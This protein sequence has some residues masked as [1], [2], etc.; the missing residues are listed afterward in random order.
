MSE[1]KPPS[2][3]EVGRALE[4][5]ERYGKLGTAEAGAP[6]QRPGIPQPSDTRSSRKKG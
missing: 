5:L 3:A 6:P 1:P 2:R 4:V